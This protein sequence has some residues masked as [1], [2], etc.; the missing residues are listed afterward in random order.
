MKKKF[1]KFKNGRNS[2][3]NKQKTPCLNPEM[4]GDIAALFC[5]ALS[6]VVFLSFL[7]IAG[8][9]GESFF[10]IIRSLF[11][12]GFFL[13]PIILIL[14]GWTFLKSKKETEIS[15]SSAELQAGEF[16]SQK[17]V[18]IGIALFILSFLALGN[19]FFP[20]EEIILRASAGQGGGY[21][22]L[23]F[24][25]PLIKLLGRWASLVVLFAVNIIAVLI[26]FNISLK[27][28]ASGF[29]IFLNRLPFFKTKKIAFKG[30]E[31]DEENE[32]EIK[33]KEEPVESEQ[34]R[35]S[36]WKKIIRKIKPD[37]KIKP[38]SSE[39]IEEENLPEEKNIEEKF[40]IPEEKKT[41]YKLPPI[42]L[43]DGG[44]EKPTSG[45]I[46]VNTEIIQKTLE[47]F[48][49][50][51]EMGEVSVGPTVTQYTLRP[52]NGVK[53][54][55]ITS[56][57]NDLSLALAA[58]PIRIE[59]PIP[60]KSLVGIEIPNKAAAIVRLKNLLES[61]QL[62]K[63][64]STL[65][66]PLGQGTSGESVIVDLARM[67]HL[68]VAGATGSGKT[69]YINNLILSLL[70]RNAPRDLKLIL[71]DPKRVELVLYNGIP[72]LLSPVIIKPDKAINSLVWAITEMERRYDSF[73]ET[74]S[75]DIISYNQKVLKKSL[76]NDY[77]KL[78]YIVIV[79]DELADLMA[80]HGREMEASIV[81]LA[82]MARAT[83]IHLVVSTQ[84]PSVEVLTGLIK[85]NITSRIAFE[86]ASLIDSRTIL[87]MAGA[88]KLLGRGD[89][90]YQSA[91]I[92]KPKRIQGAYISEE[93]VKRVVDFIRDQS[94]EDEIEEIPEKITE[95][96]SENGIPVSNEIIDDEL[97]EDAK[98]VI[99]AAGKA[100]ASLLQRRL[101]I[102][103]ARAA[104]LLDLLEEQG[105]IGPSNGAKPR[106]II[107]PENKQ[108]L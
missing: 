29:G 9:L 16:F 20:P 108:D 95:E 18:L 12:W 38:I 87:D 99:T 54:S 61:V 68:L 5:F 11:G 55:K 80:T 6:L 13:A 84:R 90:L 8:G 17:A 73:S 7:G 34:E 56:L 49:I 31:D 37:F 82:Q 42:D 104:R 89:M 78:P 45:N 101:R 92:S 35:I 30:G 40:I 63:N 62:K 52:S 70:F 100:S 28:L 86:C 3:N 43:L 69:I 22:G 46:K 60:G 88:E 21:L 75:R 53:L 2:K 79:I 14:I 27:N 98:E 26:T 77:K 4:K 24:S 85:A 36:G 15:N 71:I 103:Y 32:E 65:A 33:K 50:E 10:K 51:I 74:A 91:D 64:F 96:I 83:G 23:I 59:A 66:F 106:E 39:K 25:F 76:K 48:G 44:I 72:H 19:I 97:Y 102:G 41:D 81:R 94:F 93:E 67:P 57:Q 105:V 58:H 1:L 107:E 47:N